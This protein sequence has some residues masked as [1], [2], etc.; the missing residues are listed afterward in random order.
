MA[1]HHNN[2]TKQYF[3]FFPIE[4]LVP[5]VGWMGK[6]LLLFPSKPKLGT[7]RGR[8][9][10]LFLGMQRSSV[11]PTLDQESFALKKVGVFQKNRDTFH[12]KTTRRM[13][14]ERDST[15]LVAVVPVQDS[16]IHV[17][18]K[19]RRVTTDRRGEGAPSSRPTV[20]EHRLSP[21]TKYHKHLKSTSK[22]F[23][24]IYPAHVVITTSSPH[25]VP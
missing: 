21:R 19:A 25:T 18:E 13:G 1:S 10:V 7:W 14:W 2:A 6:C 20:V 17:E 12:H 16:N 11:S 22:D 23:V 24:A 3:I 15:F 8:R 9:V 5:T 4:I